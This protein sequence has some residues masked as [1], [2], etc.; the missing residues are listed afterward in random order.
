MASSSQRA[1]A[2]EEEDGAAAADGAATSSVSGTRAAGAPADDDALS[3]DG[4]FWRGVLPLRWSRGLPRGVRVARG[5]KRPERK[6]ERGAEPSATTAS[7]LPGA[8]AATICGSSGGGSFFN[9][10]SRSGEI[11][12]CVRRALMAPRGAG[13]S[14]NG[15]ASVSRAVAAP[16]FPGKST[17]TFRESLK[18]PRRINI[19]RGDGKL[20]PSSAGE[21]AG[22]PEDGSP[23]LPHAR[24]GFGFCLSGECGLS[25]TGMPE[26]RITSGIACWR[27][28]A[29]LLE[30]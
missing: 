10:S 11:S 12:G 27:R 23:P 17:F 7:L 14:A 2:S 3:M 9:R 26:G 18:P 8:A 28:P 16:S 15:V 22:P 1:I 13:G 21:A 25:V 4:R 24:R 5:V 19:S 29:G 30:R 20:S 6:P